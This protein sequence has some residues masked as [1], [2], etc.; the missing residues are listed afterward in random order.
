M[1]CDLSPANWLMGLGPGTGTGEG[2]SQGEGT[3][4]G[5]SSDNGTVHLI[6]FGLAHLDA[7]ATTT[8][9]TTTA[10]DALRGTLLFSSAAAMRGVRCSYKDDLECL[11]YALAYL[12]CNDL[13]WSR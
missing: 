2:E 12:L 10:T 4:P 9:T 1:H 5:G 11:A 7:D 13:P 6:D 3:T 8:T